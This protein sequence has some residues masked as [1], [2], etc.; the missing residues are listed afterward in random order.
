MYCHIIMSKENF[1]Y[2]FNLIKEEIEGQNAQ[3]RVVPSFSAICC[4]ACYRMFWSQQFVERT[5]SIKSS[6]SFT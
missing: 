1:E 5:F 6:S 2:L 4:Q 3:F